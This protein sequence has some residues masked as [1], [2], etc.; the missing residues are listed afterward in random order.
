MAL[1]YSHYREEMAR[2]GLAPAKEIDFSFDGKPHRYQVQGDKSGSRNGWFI[3]H[4]PPVGFAVFGSWKTGASHTWSAKDASTFTP[5][6]QAE[7]LAQI[8]AL[9]L[10]REKARTE[11]HAEA[12]TRAAK[13]WQMA[14]PA[15]N[16]HD[17]LRRKQV[18][19]YAIRQLNKTLL[20]PLRN[21]SGELHSLQFISEDGSKRFLSGG[22][23]SGCYFSIG[24]PSQCLLVCEGYAT[25]ATLY[26]STG[27]AT[28]CAFNAGNLYAVALAMRSK[29]PHMPIV[30]AA[31]NDIHTSGNPG[32][33]KAKEAAKAVGGAVA[34][35]TFNEYQQ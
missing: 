18:N 33:T 17:Y 26:E 22:Q 13:L 16:S 5:K 12:K 9:S 28:A 23:I 35:P 4:S 19:A 21:E 34:V 31:D 2:C 29:F 1:I 3:G 10:K 32:L 25:A 7:H 14:R 27:H 8:K 30:I 15:T 24:R 11:A 6:Q 20:I